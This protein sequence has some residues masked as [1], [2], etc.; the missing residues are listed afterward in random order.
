MIAYERMSQIIMKADDKKN[1]GKKPFFFFQERNLQSGT[2]YLIFC[3]YSLLEPHE[4]FSGRIFNRIYPT[5]SFIRQ[6]VKNFRSI[7]NL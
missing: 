1:I 6:P 5:I 4:N 7:T 2:K 3:I